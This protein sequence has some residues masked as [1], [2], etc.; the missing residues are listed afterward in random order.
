MISI[1]FYIKYIKNNYHAKDMNTFGNNLYNLLQR[2]RVFHQ[3][4]V[5]VILFPLLSLPTGNYAE[6]DGK[7]LKVHPVATLYTNL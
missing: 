3:A 6:N 7:L 5:Q 4:I 1:I 2:C